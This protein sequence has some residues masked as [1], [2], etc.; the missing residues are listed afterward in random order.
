MRKEVMRKRREN[1]DGKIK[2]ELMINIVCRMITKKTRPSRQPTE[3][4]T[5][6]KFIFSA[7]AKKTKQNKVDN[8]YDN[9]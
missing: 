3:A 6:C 1:M 9:S 2:R 5:G 7:L 4:A 8:L